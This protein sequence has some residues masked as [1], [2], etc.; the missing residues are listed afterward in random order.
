MT[1]LQN[2]KRIPG[3]CFCPPLIPIFFNQASPQPQTWWAVPPLLLLFPPFPSNND[4]PLFLS[5]QY[6]RVDPDSLFL[7]DFIF[8]LYFY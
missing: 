2:C 6:S 1:E 8:L 4:H 5:I 7:N 3:G